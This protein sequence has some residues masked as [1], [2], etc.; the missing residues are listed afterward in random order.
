MRVI[1]QEPVA[2]LG[3]RAMGHAMATSALR[4]RRAR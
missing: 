1:V 2:V 4:A 3:L